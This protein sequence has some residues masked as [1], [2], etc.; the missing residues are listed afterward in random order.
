MGI[1]LPVNDTI[2]SVQ[3]ANTMQTAAI[4]QIIQP[5]GKSLPNLLGLE[6]QMQILEELEARF[7]WN[8]STHV[9]FRMIRWDGSVLEIRCRHFQHSFMEL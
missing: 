9:R 6:I 7:R 2:L 5:N 3:K 1:N 4:H 8:Q